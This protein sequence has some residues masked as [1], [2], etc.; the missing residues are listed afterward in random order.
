VLADRLG[1]LHLPELLGAFA[2]CALGHAPAR[3]DEV[4]IAQ[5]LRELHPGGDL[6]GRRVLGQLGGAHAHAVGDGVRPVTEDGVE[7][8]LE[9]AAAL[10]GGER[11]EV[12]HAL[13]L[14]GVGG[15]GDRG[16]H[17]AL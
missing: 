10:L 2:A 15:S 8:V 5:Q 12:G 3:R 14:L 11:G 1:Q 17:R 9:D 7:E 13:Q 4:R 6:I 16:Q